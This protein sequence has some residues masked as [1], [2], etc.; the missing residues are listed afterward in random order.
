M[1]L[2]IA[3]TGMKS[4]KTDVGIMGQ[5]WNVMRP[6][7]HWPKELLTKLN[8]V[9]LPNTLNRLPVCTLIHPD[10]KLHK[11][12]SRSRW[13]FKVSPCAP[14]GDSCTVHLTEYIWS[15][16]YPIS[17]ATTPYAQDETCVVPSLL[18]T[19]GDNTWLRLT[20]EHFNLPVSRIHLQT[21]RL[22]L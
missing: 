13:T 17:I 5:T 9:L 20:A 8:G 3:L 1:K 21:I 12:T 2:T 22:T 7:K 15:R 18:C 14:V 6:R 19:A 16:M 11:L 10:W 4:C